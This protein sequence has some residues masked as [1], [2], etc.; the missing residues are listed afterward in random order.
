MWDCL[1]SSTHLPVNQLD[2]FQ[3]SIQRKCL[4]NAHS[5]ILANPLFESRIAHK[6]IKNLSQSINI[7][8][9]K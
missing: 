6:L 3:K 5:T 2:L 4:F 7:I 1:Q 9:R 8:D